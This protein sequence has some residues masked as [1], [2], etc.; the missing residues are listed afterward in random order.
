M[1][2][3]SCFKKEKVG[4]INR[5]VGPVCKYYLLKTEIKRVNG[6]LKEI[7]TFLILPESQYHKQLIH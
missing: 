2:I 5:V 6:Y 3:G 7:V 1:V 4:F